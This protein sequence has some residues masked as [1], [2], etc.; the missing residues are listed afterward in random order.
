MSGAEIYRG[1]RNASVRHKLRLLIMV[2]VTAALLCA[3][4]AILFYDHVAARDSMQNDLEVMAEM[5][6]TNSTAALSFGDE[7]AAEEI[8]S[9]LGAKRQIVAAKLLA[10]GGQTFAEYRRAFAPASIM[11]AIKADAVWF[12]KQRLVLF[13]PVVMRG[14]KLGTLYLESD[15]EQLDTRLHRFAEILVAILLG[16]WLLAFALA[17]RLQGMILDP[18]AHLGRA[19]RI[20][21]EEKEYSTRAVKIADDDLGQLTDV[22]NTMLSEIERRDEDLLR[23][24]D[25]LEQEV[26]ARTSELVDSNAALQMAKDKAEAGS[27]AKSE[28]LANMSHEI[29]TPMNGVIGMTDLVLETDLNPM[30]RN[31]LETARMSADLM[32]AVI[33]DILD[34]SKIEAGRLEL[35][36]TSFNVRDLVEESVRTLAAMAHVKRLELVGG[37]QAD[38]PDFVIGDSTR[39][40]QVLANLL[41][42]AIKFTATGEVTLEVSREQQDEEHQ[43]L[44]FV[45]QDTGIG[46]PADKQ[47]IIFEAFAQ[48][49]GSTTRKFGGTGLGLAI[50]ERLARAM[51]GRIRVE[52]EPGNG[53]RFHFTAAVGVVRKTLKECAPSAG[54]SLKGVSAIVVDDNPTNLRIL[55]ALLRSW[56][57]R[58]EIA[59]SAKCALEL[60][61][62]RMDQG[63]PFEM[64][65]TD[66]HMPETDGFGLVEQL[67]ADPAGIAQPVV[68][69]ITSGESQGDLSHSRKLGIA[70]YLTKPVRRAELHAAV[71]RA[72]CDRD[73]YD[74]E[75]LKSEALDKPRALHKEIRPTGRSL[76]ILLAEDNKV[77]QLVACGIL[78]KAGHTVEVAQDGTEVLSMLASKVFD[79]VLM[80]VQMP[81]MDGFQATA[82]IREREKSTGGHLPV[83]A[84]TAHALAG[85]KERCLAGGMDDYVSKPVSCE[86]LN[87]AL[88]RWFGARSS[89]ISFVGE[90]N[91][92]SRAVESDVIVWDRVALF[93]RLMGDNELTIKVTE[94]FLDD[95][96]RQ[97][98]ALR[99]LL[100]MGD[101][102]GCGRQSHS[103]KGASASIGAERLQVVACEMEK[104]G[105]AG[106]LG[107]VSQ[108]M[109]ELEAEFL[110]FRETMSALRS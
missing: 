78:E 83:I 13:K 10:A 40:R 93:N 32:I 2:A 66:L 96:P 98:Q 49:D 8:L 94:G 36:P 70:C 23:H 44:H 67:R 75:R 95:I 103:I 31:Y 30:Q 79:V 64:V 101:V 18:I 26:K 17:Y 27:R 12:E 28:F 3:C 90:I 108:H 20:V 81:E 91:V 80:D 52:S 56:G 65:L 9:S 110:R 82:A 4:A 57:M 15:L 88:E 84:M 104:A 99:E 89:E 58:P 48:A 5:L 105:D 19:A 85:D 87:Q 61:R 39:I 24:R 29:R 71:S 55:G 37:A 35:D 100:E 97:I 6:G 109:A 1:Y 92:S 50:S 106:D 69:M 16:A 102:S 21:S 47:A 68:L 76:H 22:F 43:I 41:G 53:S 107:A 86:S 38:V 74:G 25:G 59:T 51:G 77:N 62:L 33:N 42:N 63:T 72:L 45:V 60:I 14:E 11:P 46:I 73:D 54:V 34:F 7:K